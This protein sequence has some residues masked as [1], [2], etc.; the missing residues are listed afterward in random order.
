MSSSMPTPMKKWREKGWKRLVLITY[1]AS[2]RFCLLFVELN[3]HFHWSTVKAWLLLYQN[4]KIDLKISSQDDKRSLYWWWMM[5]LKFNKVKKIVFGR[6][7]RKRN[8]YESNLYGQIRCQKLFS[9]TV[10]LE[11]DFHYSKNKHRHR[12]NGSEDANEKHKHKHTVAWTLTAQA[13]KLNQNI[14]LLFLDLRPPHWFTTF[15]LC[16]YF[17]VCLCCSENQALLS[18]LLCTE[19][20][21]V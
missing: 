19:I 11:S 16:L 7:T 14:I 18:G 4:F 8:P 15:N 20:H 17:C 9:L 3:K 5:V 2:S 13:Y 1:C 21:P 6:N 10:L 12:Q